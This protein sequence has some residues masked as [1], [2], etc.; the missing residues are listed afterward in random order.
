MA[1]LG[2]DAEMAELFSKLQVSKARELALEMENNELRRS[3][4]KS[5]SEVALSREY[6]LLCQERLRM[7]QLVEQL[8]LEK[9]HLI[10]SVVG[11]SNDVDEAHRTRFDDSLKYKQEVLR[12]SEDDK[13]SRRKKYQMG[14]GIIDI[15]KARSVD[16][17]VQQEV[18]MHITNASFSA[19]PTASGQSGGGLAAAG[20]VSGKRMP[21]PFGVPDNSD[22]VAMT[23]AFTNKWPRF[24]SIHILKS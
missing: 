1:Q 15:L 24:F 22:I 2:E 5:T 12:H 9:E 6:E 19:A 20:V 3:L 21:I 17:L 4:R 14:L 13:N 8:R 18:Q 23:T 10:E 11:L 16:P 7:A